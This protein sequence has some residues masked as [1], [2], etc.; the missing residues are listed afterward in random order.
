[1]SIYDSPEKLTIRKSTVNIALLVI[2]A[3]VPV[4]V[5]LISFILGKNASD[6]FIWWLTLFAF[7]AAAF[8]F[9]A[10]I[11]RNFR[12]KGYGF[13]KAIGILFTSF[14]VWTFTY[15]RVLSFSK[16]WVFAAL[17]I[18]AAVCWGIPWTR[19][20]A[21]KALSSKG[22][23][24]EIAWSEALFAV[25]LL[26]FCFLKGISPEINGEEKFMDFA[27]LN[28][29]IRTETL[30][31]PDPW[32]AGQSINYYYFG[33]YIY[34]FLAKFNGIKPGIA[35]VLSMCTS[36]AIAFSMAYS[37]GAMVFEGA[38][39]KGLKAPFPVRIF[40]GLLSA[41]AVCVMGNSHSFFYDEKGPG[42]N[43]LKFL[44]TTGVK[45]GRV[46]G[47]FYPDSTRF[48]GHNPDVKVIDDLGN[49]LHPGDYTIHEFPFYSFLIG[50]LHAHVVSMMIVLLIIAVFF[51][52]VFRAEPPDA[53]ERQINTFLSMNTANQFGI[54]LRTELKRLLKP[55]ILIVALLLSICTMCNY[56]DFLI[57]FIFSAMAL[58]IYHAISSRHFFSI[59]GTPMFFA[60]VGAI[61]F[62]YLKYSSMP[63]NH[64]F[65]QLLV[66]GICL[67]GA[68]VSP[69]AL[70]RTGLGM[71]FLFTSASLLSL[72]FQSQFE[73]I[74][75]AIGQVKTRTS[76]YQFIILWSVHILL[77]VS[78]I[79]LT[80]F[81][82]PPKSE[83]KEKVALEYDSL[84][85]TNAVSRFFGM[86]NRVDI[87][88][89][90]AAI[91]GFLMLLAPEL[92]YVRDIYEGDYSRANTMFKFAFAA[93]ILLSIVLGYTVFRFLFH[94]DRYGNPSVP[95]ICF[96]TLFALLLFIPAHYPN[97]ALEQ[98]SGKIIWIE[99]KEEGS[100]KIIRIAEYK[101][102][103]GTEALLMRDSGLIPEQGPDLKS[104]AEAIDYLNE[105]V[106][107]T[108]VICEVY[109]DSYTD[110]C[111]VSAYTG[112]PTIFGWQTHEWLW[113]FQGIEND[114]GKIVQNPDKPDLWQDIIIPRHDAVDNIYI[115]LDEEIA[116]N[117]LD[118]YDVTYLIVGELERNH[119]GFLDD[120][121]LQGLGE[122]V[123][124]RDDLYIVK[125]Q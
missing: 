124:S 27:F 72:P 13:S 22:D 39:R 37:I 88:M 31:A 75:N 44:E 78:L 104:Y 95:A 1:M 57:Y 93:F 10:L 41:F 74:S 20:E 123:F 40:A 117:Y 47:F 113:R 114:E 89:C 63:G 118:K 79:V 94:R 62:V 105:F 15:L 3:S 100:G 119:Y 26:V 97:V 54:S 125:V 52:F 12:T 116:R 25:A 77:A 86:K 55:E 29:L 50:D 121:F 23:V 67:I 16:F 101:G 30:P 71:S 81:S 68:A 17:F 92:I 61:L 32:L 21:L 34:A 5:L 112:L 46:D 43:F 69:S 106:T 45:T 80:I 56:W 53:G 99:N 107:G 42:N 64:V 51:L 83:K 73:M 6:Y 19:N 14:F 90:G 8:P 122:V 109:G 11:F 48:I 103:D 33:Q 76:L 70:T 58:L 85:Y 49:L 120:S 28:S 87:F 2:L 7:G 98:R 60:Q 111:V 115:S 108:P 102:L 36:I 4:F 59:A 38:I 35:Y 84:S 66:F 18:L 65:L 24:Y 96:F 82:R 9:T 91:V 110:N